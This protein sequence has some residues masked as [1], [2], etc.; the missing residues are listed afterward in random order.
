MA[1]AL[2]GFEGAQSTPKAIEAT[3]APVAEAASTPRNERGKDPRA[4]SQLLAGQESGARSVQD[5]THGRGD[6]DC[7]GQ[8]SAAGGSDGSADGG[9]AAAQTGGTPSAAGAT[10]ADLLAIAA[11]HKNGQGVAAAGTSLFSAALVGPE[12]PQALP[13]QAGSA[14]R[15]DASGEEVMLGEYTKFRADTGPLSG[16]LPLRGAMVSLADGLPV[17]GSAVPLASGLPVHGAAVPLATEQA[18]DGGAIA[19]EAAKGADPIRVAGELRGAASAVGRA[20]QPADTSA[21]A[22]TP[23]AQ[24]PPGSISVPSGVQI[25]T[26]I[27]DS[28]PGDRGES[29]TH[30]EQTGAASPVKPIPTSAATAPQ[31]ETLDPAVAERAQPTVASQ[32]A[33][34]NPADQILPDTA[35]QVSAVVAGGGIPAGA[36][37]SSNEAAALTPTAGATSSPA[38]ESNSGAPVSTTPAVGSSEA[39]TT[40]TAIRSQVMQGLAGV[41][42]ARSAQATSARLGL[43][44]PRDLT[45]QLDP[46]QLGRVD[47]RFQLQNNTLTVTFTAT[48]AEAEQALREGADELVQSLLRRGGE[49]QRVDVRFAGPTEQRDNRDN[50]EKRDSRENRENRDGNQNPHEGPGG[51]GQEQQAREDQRRRENRVSGMWPQQGGAEWFAAEAAVGNAS[52]QR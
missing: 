28:S 12:L 42:S 10:A 32:D 19:T 50:T 25:G 33:A 17:R 8:P 5:E 48:G 43:G 39:T 3:T 9:Q 46:A 44:Q 34:I 41:R 22:S 18:L 40:A 49:W 16:G 24:T 30:N 38:A 51:R 36:N 20:A 15:G 14:V 7:V 45:L 1:A 26:P 37:A 6:H 2:P 21:S 27:N 23:P 13:Q 47:V 31:P 4:F 35:A 29:G 52:E 11:Q